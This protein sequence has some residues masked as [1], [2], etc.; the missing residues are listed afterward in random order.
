LLVKN[1]VWNHKWPFRGFVLVRNPFSVV[2]SFRADNEPQ[3]RAVKRKLQ[4]E[5]WARRIDPALLPALKNMDTIS[6][7]CMLYNRKMHD[8]ASSGLPI[9]RYEDFVESPELILRTLL[10]RLELPWDEAVLNSHSNYNNGELGHGKIRLWEPIHN[11]SSDSWKDMHPAIRSVIYGI[12]YPTMNAFG[13]SY[14]GE[15]LTRKNANAFI[16]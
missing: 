14:D 11:R 9:V 3:K 16:I 7:V 6:Y 2:N 1:A 8:L 4:L 13:Y 5:R 15:T 12:T 10:N